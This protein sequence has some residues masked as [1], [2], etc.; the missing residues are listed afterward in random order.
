M[1]F[2]VPGQRAFQTC[3]VIVFIL[4]S[5]NLSMYVYCIQLKYLSTFADRLYCRGVFCAKCILT[6]QTLCKSIKDKAE[7]HIET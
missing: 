7:V 5:L 3:F 2:E 4:Q 1:A 6:V